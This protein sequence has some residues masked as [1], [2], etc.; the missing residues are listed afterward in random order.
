[1]FSFIWSEPAHRIPNAI[2]PTFIARISTF[3]LE[4]M[5]SASLM[6][7]R[8]FV[9][10]GSLAEYGIYNT[11]ITEES[12]CQPVSEYSKAKLAVKE[13]GTKLSETVEY[14]I[15]ASA[16]FQHLRRLYLQQ[17]RYHSICSDPPRPDQT[18]VPHGMVLQP[19]IFS[20][21]HLP[22]PGV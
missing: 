6:R 2:I 14:K 22:I 13:A 20:T 12:P 21:Y 7:C 10:A 3:T 17:R 18:V 4:A 8:L 1:M 9:E 16:H 11:I 5:Q 19:A 15:P